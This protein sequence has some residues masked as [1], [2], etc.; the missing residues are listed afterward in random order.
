MKYQ[1][2]GVEV[3]DSLEL[4]LKSIRKK[5]WWFKKCWNYRKK[6][7]SKIKWNW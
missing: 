7:A 6:I 1:K 2:I 4:S 5:N 3:I